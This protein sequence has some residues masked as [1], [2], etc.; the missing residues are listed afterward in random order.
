MGSSNVDLGEGQNILPRSPPVTT[1]CSQG[2]QWEVQEGVEEEHSQK[3]LMLDV[4]VVERTGDIFVDLSERPF[5]TPPLSTVEAVGQSVSCLG[6]T[7]CGVLPL[8]LSVTHTR[9]N[10]LSCPP[11]PVAFESLQRRKWMTVLGFTTPTCREGW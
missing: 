7:F 9:K 1:K 10:V 2:T 8:G 4:E 6:G 11:P 3:Y 5:G